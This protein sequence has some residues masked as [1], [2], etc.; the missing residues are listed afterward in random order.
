MKNKEEEVKD[1]LQETVEETPEKEV[2]QEQETD[3]TADDSTGDC[4]SGFCHWSGVC[5]DTCKQNADCALGLTCSALTSAG[6]TFADSRCISLR[7]ERPTSTWAYQDKHT[8]TQASYMFLRPRI[9]QM[10]A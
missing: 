6:R 4:A 8:H 1:N 5:L 7:R 3:S 2:T 9:G 10:S